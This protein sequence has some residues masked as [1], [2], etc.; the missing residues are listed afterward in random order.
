MLLRLLSCVGSLH[1]QTCA[2][3]Q[4]LMTEAQSLLAMLEILDW[5][6]RLAVK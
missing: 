3:C 2:V 4:G 1:E 6:H 5:K